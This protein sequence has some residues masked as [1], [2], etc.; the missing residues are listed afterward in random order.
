MNASILFEIVLFLA[1]AVII[2]PLSKRLGLGNVLGFLVAGVAIGPWGF[3]F[4]H[5]VDNIRHLSE[6]GVVLLLFIIGLEL[7][8]SRL[9]ALRRPVFLLGGAQVLGTGTLLL[10]AGLAFG[11]SFTAALIMGIVLSFSSTAFALQ[12]L[13]ERKQ[14]T[15]HFGRTSFAVLLFQDLAAIPLLAVVPLLTHAT[16]MHGGASIMAVLEAVAVIVG[17]IVGGRFLLRPLLRFAAS[18]VSQEILTAA[19][20]LIVMGTALLLQQVGLSMALG[21]FL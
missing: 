15:T 3:K 19:A 16:S 2:V 9:W 5:D 18:T 10:L 11:L 12:L 20:L 17:L 8:P 1:A 13:A 7:Q 4:V 14:L 21:A 6:L